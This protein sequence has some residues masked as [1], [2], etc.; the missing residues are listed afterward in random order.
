MKILEIT[1]DF[2][3]IGK[4]SPDQLIR[5]Q[6]LD[7]TDSE[8]FTQV[9]GRVFFNVVSRIIKNDIARG[10]SARGLDTL[11]IY[12]VGDYNKMKCFLGKNNSSGY[13]LTNTGELVSVFSSQ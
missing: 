1:E 12:A 5:G 2:R 13:A 8:N 6:R 3:D 7:P 11:T 9:E 4:L 10:D